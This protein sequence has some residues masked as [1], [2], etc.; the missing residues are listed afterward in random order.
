MPCA[1]CTRLVRVTPLAHLSPSL[2]ASF[3]FAEEHT[4]P[5]NQ[6]TL[7]EKE[8]LPL[9]APNDPTEERCFVLVS[10][11]R[12]ASVVVDVPPF[13]R[14]CWFPLLA[15]DL[16]PLSLSSSQLVLGPSNPPYPSL[17]SLS[18]LVPFPSL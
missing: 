12:G 15:E 10:L 13:F 4:V 5:F 18:Y 8:F 16:P 9:S 7:G 1:A 17:F 11:R 6:M 14:I 2:S 3:F